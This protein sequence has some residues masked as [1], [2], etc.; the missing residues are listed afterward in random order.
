MACNITFCVPLIFRAFR[1]GCDVSRANLGNFP[2]PPAGNRSSPAEAKS[3]L[4]GGGLTPADRDEL[5]HSLKGLGVARRDGSGPSSCR[6][7]FL[8]LRETPLLLGHPEMIESYEF[9]P[10]W[11]WSNCPLR[12]SL[13]AS[14]DSAVEMPPVTW[15]PTQRVSSDSKSM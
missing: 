11:T 9:L 5:L 10:I 15:R 1:L 2:P 6:G 14:W 12:S 7:C 13:C 8:F 3:P 4:L